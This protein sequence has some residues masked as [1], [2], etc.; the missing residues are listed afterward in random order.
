ANA[1]RAASDERTIACIGEFNSGATALSLPIL[2]EAGIL[3]VSPSNTYPGLTR[4]EGA[5][6]GEP[7]K[8]Y[9]TGR[10]T[11]GRVSPADHMEAAAMVRYLQLL[12]VR[13]A[14]LV[15]DGDLYGSA[16]MAMVKTR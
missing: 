8:Y 5:A 13:R 14:F 16:M 12:R 9:P 15:D 11:Y 4:R 7:D 3:Q 6:R 10:R 1:R 2:N